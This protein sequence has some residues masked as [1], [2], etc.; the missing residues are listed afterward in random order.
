MLFLSVTAKPDGLLGAIGPN[1]KLGAGA[2][3]LVKLAEYLAVP[4]VILRS[5]MYP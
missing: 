2:A 4:L 1:P 5:S 3:G